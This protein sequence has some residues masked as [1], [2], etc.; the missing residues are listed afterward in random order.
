M[1]TDPTIRFDG[2]ALVLH[3]PE[4]DHEISIPIERCE[5]INNN[6]GTPLPNQRGWRV[7]LDV[8]HAR[9]SADCREKRTISTPAGPTI[10]Q[11]EQALLAKLPPKR[12]TVAKAELSL[13]DLDL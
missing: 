7:L 6:W 8:L 12:K 11:I 4:N 2:N 10:Y 3:F 9:Y 1:K 5:V 13:E